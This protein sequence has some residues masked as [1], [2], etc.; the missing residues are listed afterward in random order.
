MR[1]AERI[2]RAN[3]Y[4]VWKERGETEGKSQNIERGVMREI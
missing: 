4:K 1:K 2:A 3:R